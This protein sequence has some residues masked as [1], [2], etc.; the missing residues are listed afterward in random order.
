[1]NPIYFEVADTQ[2]FACFLGLNHLNY[3]TLISEP[4]TVV[5]MLFIWGILQLDSFQNFLVAS[6]CGQV[7]SVKRKKL[8]WWTQ[9]HAVVT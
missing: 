1:M 2:A 3:V 9:T 7:A 8:F 5:D 6:D 4:V